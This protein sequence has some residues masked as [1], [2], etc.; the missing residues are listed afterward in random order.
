MER[1]F[2]CF[3]H[4]FKLFRELDEGVAYA[5]QKVAHTLHFVKRNL[6]ILQGRSEAKPPLL[7]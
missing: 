1:Y 3:F 2:Y 5:L 4:A 6:L 7:D